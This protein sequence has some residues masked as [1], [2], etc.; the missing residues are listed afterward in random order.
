MTFNADWPSDEN[1]YLYNGKELEDDLS[2]DWYDYGARMYDPAIGRWHVV[3]PLAEEYT[4][5]S[6]YN[7][8]LNNP[9]RFI[10]PDGRAVTSPIYDTEGNFLGTDDEGLQGD[11]IVMDK[12][13]FKQGMSHESA[14]EKGTTL[15]NMPLVSKNT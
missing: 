13:E 9:I 7:Y 14:M 3:D 12:K 5:F 1:E 15:D 8:T 6:P 11:A 10:D 4:P 2:L